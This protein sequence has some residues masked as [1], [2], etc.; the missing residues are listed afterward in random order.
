M[1]A[2]A[3]RFSSGPRE[4][5]LMPT[6]SKIP[7]FG[8]FVGHAAIGAGL[9]VFLSLVP[10]I[11]DTGHVFK[12]IINSS[13]PKIIFLTFVAIFPYGAALTGLIFSAIEDS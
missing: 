5:E 11:S 6:R 8:E 2:R 3:L 4:N 9:G 1:A 10:I 12:I 7:G 13:N